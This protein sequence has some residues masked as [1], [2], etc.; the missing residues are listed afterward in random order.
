M[1]SLIGSLDGLANA[2]LTFQQHVVAPDA[3]HLEQLEGGGLPQQ[4]CAAIANVAAAQ[5]RVVFRIVRPQPFAAGIVQHEHVVAI[6]D[7]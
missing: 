1:P 5:A 4:C 6:S 2:S 3:L 7:L